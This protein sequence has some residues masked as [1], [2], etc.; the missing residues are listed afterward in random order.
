[1]LIY[2]KKGVIHLSK[3]ERKDYS[4]P[5]NLLIEQGLWK[6]GIQYIAGVDECGRGPF[7]GPVVAG[8]VIM[9]KDFRI[10]RLT[11][12]KKIPKKEHKIFADLVKEKA[13]SYNIGIASVNEIDELN[14]LE[15]TKLAMK[16]AV[17]G[18]ELKPDFLLIDG[19]IVLNN[20]IQENFVIKG[21]YNSHSISAGAIIAKVYRDELMEELDKQY[22]SK[23]GWAKNAGY[24]TK[25]HIEACEKYGVT[26]EHRKSWKTMDKFR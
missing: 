15:A 21:D 14:I 13:L 6:S 23:Y 19:N 10:P 25:S 4:K 22:E 24:Q 8:A 5:D 18:L 3:K 7:A 17:E 11:D 1:M 16:R 9:P 20:N 12:S 26:K 2:K